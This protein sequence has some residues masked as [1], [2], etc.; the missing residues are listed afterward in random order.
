[1]LADKVKAMLHQDYQGISAD[2]RAVVQ[3]GLFVAYPGEVQD[4]RDYIAQA[5]KKGA[6]GVIHEQEENTREVFDWQQTQVAHLGVHALKQQVGH[7][8]AEYYGNPSDTCDV[9]GVT[10]TNGKTTVTQWLAQCFNALTKKTAVVGTIGYGMPGQLKP[11]INTTPDAIVLQS[12]MA[13]LVAEKYAVVAMEVSSH[14]LVQERVQ[15]VA[16]DWA[17]FTNLTRDHLDY[18]QTMAAYGAAKRRLLEWDSL[19]AAIINTDDAFGREVAQ[20][21]L[22]NGNTVITYGLQSGLNS[23]HVSAEGLRFDQNGLTMQVTYGNERFSVN[24]DIVGDFNAVNL[25]AVITTLLKHGFTAAQIQEAVSSI[26]PVDGRMQKLGGGAQPMVVVDYAHSPAALETVLQS[27]QKHCIDGAR[28]WCVFGCGGNRD[29]G[30]RSLMGQ[31]AQQLADL[32]IVTS[33]NPRDEAPMAII[34]DIEVGLNGGAYWV[35]LDRE[36]AIKKALGLAKPNDV[37]LI[38]GKGHENYQE[39]AGVRQPFSDMDIAEKCLQEVQ[40]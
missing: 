18:H 36:A 40:A 1:M 27:L 11:T 8:A 9:I 15:G 39:I 21:L 14:G 7:I 23:E 35:E 6:T 10:G 29:V 3:D 37:V 19:Q 4:G 22:D 28:L 25:L 33:D 38:A 31:A 2:S 34:Q 30:K 17:I 20:V 16:F 13:E 24:A 26:T 12:M 32:V 5:I